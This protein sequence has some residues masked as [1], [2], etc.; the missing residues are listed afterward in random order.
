MPQ[1]TAL[2]DSVRRWT[3]AVGQHRARAQRLKRD[4][5]GL[6]SPCDAILDEAL[7]LCSNLLIDLAGAE[8]QTSKL[9]EAL[10]HEREDAAGLFER[11]PIAS[12][13][14]DAAGV[15]ADANRGAALL[16]NV[17][18]RHL[19][20]KPLLHFTQDRVAFFA[21]LKSLA[22]EAGTL[23]VSIPIRPRERRATTV[24]VVV[25][26]QTPADP[27]RLLWFLTP[28]ATA[29]R[30]AVQ[31]QDPAHDTDADE[32]GGASDSYGSASHI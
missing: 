4:T 1:L 23:H 12:I 15:I 14:T 17:S 26:R 19:A 6:A 10:R 8:A 7:E 2:S 25:L 24:S 30:A 9:R 3:L 20:G 16:L 31:Q 13:S 32:A 27:G 22:R 18:A 11:I 5:A 28:D 21:L 29:D